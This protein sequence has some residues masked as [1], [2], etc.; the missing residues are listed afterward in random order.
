MKL[1]RLFIAAAASMLL[2]A[3]ATLAA[4]PDFYERLLNR[5]ASYV[6]SGNNAAAARDLRI[7]AFGY[8]GSLPEYERAHV[9][10]AIAS[11]RMTREGDARD[12]IERVLAAE[13]IEPHFYALQLPAPIVTEFNSVA[14]KVLAPEQLARLR[15][16]AA[17]PVAPAPAPS[18]VPAPPAQ[19]PPP[20]PVK[21]TPAVP[22]T[23]P[24][25]PVK[26]DFAG[27]LIDAEQAIAANDL[28][29]AR[30]IF[31]TLVSGKLD[32]AQA[33]RVAEGAY[34]A[35]DFESVVKAM[36][37]AGRLKKREE[38]YRYYLAVALFETGDVK[39]ARKEL[40]AAL[41]HVEMT[42]DVARNRARIEA[43]K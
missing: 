25:V 13:A 24:S 29:S 42:E 26:K 32:H 28:A 37:T 12:S 41:P 2:A 7:A 15:A 30:T 1:R 20:A 14:Q 16:A 10:L 38:H 8:V 4:G 34:R 17:T 9:Y 35:R 3:P 40:A 23:A 31:R 27:Q 6:L 36:K 19:E 22:A 21:T 18:P 11:A 43:A 33:L 39:R 5:G